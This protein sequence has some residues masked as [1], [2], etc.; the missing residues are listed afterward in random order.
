MLAYVK[1]IDTSNPT[2]DF[3]HIIFKYDHL[4]A[5]TYTIPSYNTGHILGIYTDVMFYVA[6]PDNTNYN[7]ANLPHN[8]EFGI[9]RKNG[10]I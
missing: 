10:N 4:L 2:I 9:I 1:D 5:N 8:Q 3:A 7:S 6:W